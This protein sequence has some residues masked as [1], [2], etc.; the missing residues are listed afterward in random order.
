MTKLWIDGAKDYDKMDE[1]D[2]R[3]YHEL[4]NWWLALH[5]NIYHQWK[6][7]TSRPRNVRCMDS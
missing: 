3:R 6:R 7:E 1:I 4:V 2:K 5:E